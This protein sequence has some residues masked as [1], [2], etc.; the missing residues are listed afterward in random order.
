[1]ETLIMK[2]LIVDDDPDIRTI[3]RLSLCRVG[4]MEV[5]EAAGGAEGLQRARQEQPDAILLDL[6]MPGMDGSATLAAL[7][8]CAATASI[9]VIFLTA[10]ALRSEVDH[11]ML[12]G[13]AGVLIKPFDPRTLADNVRTL[14]ESV[15]ATPSYAPRSV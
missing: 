13:A 4:G 10:K 7:R 2:V 5:I 11:L 1:M 14:V 8:A 9:P 3:G 15:D 6:M 12:L